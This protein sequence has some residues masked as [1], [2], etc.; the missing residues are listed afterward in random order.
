MGNREA[1]W[2]RGILLIAAVVLFAIARD[3]GDASPFETAHPSEYDKMTSFAIAPNVTAGLA[4]AGF[5][6]AGGLSLLGSAFVRADAA[7]A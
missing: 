6:L 5:A 2:F 1:R 7:A 3:F 4:S